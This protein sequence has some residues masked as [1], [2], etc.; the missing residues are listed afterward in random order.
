MCKLLG[1][2]DVSNTNDIFQSLTYKIVNKCT[3]GEMKCFIMACKKD[4]PRSKHPKKALWKVPST[5]TLIYS[6][7]YFSV[8]HYLT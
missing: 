3:C 5:E 7:W 6:H 2:D 4:L 1:K 8:D